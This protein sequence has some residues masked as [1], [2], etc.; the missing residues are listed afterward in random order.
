MCYQS[1]SAFQQPRTHESFTSQS[2]RSCFGVC[3]TLAARAFKTSHCITVTNSAGSWSSAD[4]TTESLRDF[5]TTL[6]PQVQPCSTTMYRREI[7][8][9][10]S[11]QRTACARSVSA[12]LHV[13]CHIRGTRC[14]SQRHYPRSHR[15]G[16]TAKRNMMH[17][18]SLRAML[19]VVHSVPHISD[20]MKPTGCHQTC[21]PLTPL[22]GKN[23]IVVFC[24]NEMSSNR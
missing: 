7:A 15:P 12:C 4:M 6:Q 2:Q 9:L 21:F 16:N 18:F 20:R 23:V 22:L 19:H 11:N 3:G 10:F 8:T 14:L 1:S 17:L 5:P 13:Y 24:R